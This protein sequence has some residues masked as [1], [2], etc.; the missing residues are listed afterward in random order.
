MCDLAARMGV[1]ERLVTLAEVQAK[2]MFEAMNRA[3][4]ARALTAEQRAPG[5]G[6]DGW[7]PAGRGRRG[8]AGTPRRLNARKP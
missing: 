6:D 2:I 7:P 1:E 5:A 3:L 8:V 4:D